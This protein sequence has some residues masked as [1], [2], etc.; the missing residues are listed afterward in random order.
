MPLS[1]L[2]IYPH[3]MQLF[4]NDDKEHCIEAHLS[5]TRLEVIISVLYTYG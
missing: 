3:R 4:Y 5:S 2:Q 1:I